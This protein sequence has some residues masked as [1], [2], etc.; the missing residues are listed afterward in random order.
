MTNEEKA[1]RGRRANELLNDPLVVE[2]VEYVDQLYWAE[3]RNSPA[4]D[5]EGREAIYQRLKALEDVMAR[6]KSFAEDGKL[7][8]RE[9]DRAKSGKRSFF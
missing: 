6:L 9:I 2:S 7:A 1:A 5:T 4:R 3:W 8:Q